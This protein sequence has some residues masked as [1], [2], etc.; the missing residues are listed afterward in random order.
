MQFAL[1]PAKGRIY[2][3]PFQPIAD[4]CSTHTDFHFFVLWNK[5]AASLAIPKHGSSHSSVA[6]KNSLRR[7]RPNSLWLVR[8]E[9][10]TSPRSLLWRHTHL[11]GDRNST[12]A[13]PS[14]WKSEKRTARLSGKK[15]ALYQTLCLVCRQAMSQQ[16]SVGH[17]LRVEPGLA[18]RQRTGQ[19]IYDRATGTCWNARTKSDWA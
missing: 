3:W 10:S 7:L 12:S 16:H 17:C 19:A 14:L 2:R 6:Q 11:S 13:L 18:H 5:Y 4:A 15:P 9:A 8:Q 1:V